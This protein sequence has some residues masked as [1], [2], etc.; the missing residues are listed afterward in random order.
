MTRG[1]TRLPRLDPRPV[2]RTIPRMTHDALEHPLVTE[3]LDRLTAIASERG[4]DVESC[5]YEAVPICHSK[6]IFE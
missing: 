5:R 3:A 4:I 6:L 1:A 2:L